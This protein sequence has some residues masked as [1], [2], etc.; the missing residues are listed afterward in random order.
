LPGLAGR[1]VGLAAPNSV[2]HGGSSPMPIAASTDTAQA[3]VPAAA[4]QPRDR[5]GHFAWLNRPG[6][7]LAALDRLVNDCNYTTYR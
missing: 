4:V 3:I 2:V 6:V 1:L 5:V 7:V